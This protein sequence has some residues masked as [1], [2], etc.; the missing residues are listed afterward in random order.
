MALW[1]CSLPGPVSSFDNDQFRVLRELR[2]RPGLDLQDHAGHDAVRHMRYVRAYMMTSATKT[3]IH[4]QGSWLAPIPFAQ[5]YDML[6]EGQR[7]SLG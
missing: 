1:F 3:T 4:V 6:D 7:L 2:M 5:G